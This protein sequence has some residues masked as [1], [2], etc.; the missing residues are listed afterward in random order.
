MFFN[1]RKDATPTPSVADVITAAKAGQIT[2]IDVRE[3]GELAASGTAAGALHIPVALIA[4]RADPKSPDYDKR[5]NPEAPI[6]VFCA[7]GG[8]SGM[9][10]QALQRLGYSAVVNI[11]GFANWTNAGGPISR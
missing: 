9:A 6:A 5:L 7:S 8:R 11:G 4:M 2:V 10:Q 3:A 1:S